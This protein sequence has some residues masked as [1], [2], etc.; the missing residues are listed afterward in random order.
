MPQHS[1]MLGDSV[2]VD[3]QGAINAG[4]DQVFV[5]HL[6]VA[7]EV[8]PTYTVHSLRELETIF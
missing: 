3:I 2:E 8:K 4:I 7:A 5:N 1:I 6:H